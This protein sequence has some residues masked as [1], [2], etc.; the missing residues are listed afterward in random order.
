MKTYDVHVIPKCPNCGDRGN[1][2]TIHAKTKAEAI[3]SARKEIW[4]ECLYDQQD[5]P[6]VYTAKEKEN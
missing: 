6:L 1:T 4:R 5:W 2:L 3:S